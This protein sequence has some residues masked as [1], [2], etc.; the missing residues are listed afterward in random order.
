MG[1]EFVGSEGRFELDG[2][3]SKCLSEDGF[4][5]IHAGDETSDQRRRTRPTDF[6]VEVGL[7]L[8]L[9]F[10]GLERQTLA[11][12]VLGVL[13]GAGQQSLT[14]RLRGDF[15]ATIVKVNFGG[16]VK[17]RVTASKPLDFLVTIV[18]AL[19]VT[20]KSPVIRCDVFFSFFFVSA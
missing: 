9:P 20:K 18:F 16:A 17:H 12:E 5:V 3:A 11:R 4:L 6:A 2:L 7:R 15:G 8:A 14:R 1:I 19:S 13:V 10:R